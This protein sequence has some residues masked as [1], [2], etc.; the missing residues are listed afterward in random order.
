MLTAEYLSPY[1][2]LIGQY[3]G[4]IRT[5][6]SNSKTTKESA[7][8]DFDIFDDLDETIVFEAS[9]QSATVKINNVVV[10]EVDLPVSEVDVYVNIANPSIPFIKNPKEF[11]HSAAVVA[12]SIVTNP[13][14]SLHIMIDQSHVR[15]KYGEQEAAFTIEVI[16]VEQGEEAIVESMINVESYFAAIAS[17]Y[18]SK[19]YGVKMEQGSQNILEKTKEIAEKTGEKIVEGWEK[20]QVEAKEKVKDMVLTPE[21]KQVLQD[22][23]V[24]VYMKVRDIIERFIQ[25]VITFFG[26]LKAELSRILSKIEPQAESIVKP[27]KDFVSHY[28]IIVTAVATAS[29][30]GI[31][32]LIMKKRAVRVAARE[33]ASIPN[34]KLTYVVLDDI[35]SVLIVTNPTL[36]VKQVAKEAVSIFEQT[37]KKGINNFKKLASKF[38]SKE[39]SVK[40]SQRKVN[41]GII[42]ALVGILKAATPVVGAGIFGFIIGLLTAL[43]TDKIV[44]AAKQVQDTAADVVQKSGEIVEKIDGEVKQTAGDVAEKVQTTGKSLIEKLQQIYSDIP[45]FTKVGVAVLIGV[46]VI[47]VGAKILQTLRK[48]HIVSTSMD[49]NKVMQ[50]VKNM[51]N[52]VFAFAYTGK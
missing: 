7:I 44:E 26:K 4:V 47:L 30:V 33:F 3:L 46:G 45:A 52:R 31:I 11:V 50:D 20:L 42:P 39:A 43:N 12:N 2:L 29:I 6:V 32:T 21:E 16:N 49:I 35:A 27:I 51:N 25:E 34:D 13:G 17:S 38:V 18:I 15:S 5:I 37:G 1:S 48:R 19:V 28:P 40:V 23:F 41:P 36:D 8:E 10:G 22:P 9:K 14:E 24:K